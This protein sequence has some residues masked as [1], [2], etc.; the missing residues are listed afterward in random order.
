MLDLLRCPHC[1]RA[2]APADGSARCGAGHSF[3]FARQ[4]YLS[5]LP[6]DAALGSADTAQMVAARAAF[7]EAGHFELLARALADEA[8]RVTNGGAVVDLG[9]GTGWYLARVLDRLPDRTGLALDLSKHALRRAARAHPRIGAVACD[10]WRPLPVRDDV[11]ALALSVFAPRHGSE[12]ARILRPG[13]TLLT[14]TP[15]AR[16]LAE[17]VAALDLLR[18][19]EQKEKRLARRLEPYLQPVRRSELEWRLELSREETLD[20]AAMGPSAFHAGRQQLRPRVA[21]LPEPLAVTASVRISVYSPSGPAT[22]T[23]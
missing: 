21:K 8:A 18:V 7:L 20:A 14:V 13:G 15:T 10:V 17:L 23:T 12:I 19:D 3:D 4:G 11:A 2:L 5:L 6:G 1:G 9:A 16:H 22:P